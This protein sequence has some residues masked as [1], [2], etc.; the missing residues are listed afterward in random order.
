VYL[1]G[2]LKKRSKGTPWKRRWIVLEDRFL[3]YFKSNVE[4]KPLRTIL[5][6]QSVAVSFRFGSKGRPRFVIHARGGIFHFVCD[7]ETEFQQWYESLDA[8]LHDTSSLPPWESFHEETNLPMIRRG[9]AILRKMRALALWLSASAAE[10]LP[11]LGSAMDTSGPSSSAVTSSPES[12]AADAY[13]L[14]CGVE[15]ETFSIDTKLRCLR[16]P[17]NVAHLL[18]RLFPE[19]F[20]NFFSY[21][22]YCCSSA[23]FGDLIAFLE[24]THGLQVLDTSPEQLKEGEEDAIMSLCEVIVLFKLTGLCWSRLDEHRRLILNYVNTHC[25]DVGPISNLQSD[26]A[27][28]LV[29]C[30]MLTKAKSDCLNM[31]E[32]REKSPAERIQN[33]LQVAFHQFGVI[34]LLEV[35]D[36]VEPPLQDPFSLLVYTTQLKNVI[37]TQI[38]FSLKPLKPLFLKGKRSLE[39]STE[40][41]LSGRR[42]SRATIFVHCA[43][44]WFER[45]LRLDDDRVDSHCA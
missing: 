27:D 37:E 19:S 30:S 17:C 41:Q 26:L 11:V 31:D 10:Q 33:A 18:H 15:G 34:P 42:G 12:A 40:L 4:S 14:A 28:G 39:L 24:N 36:V 29:W 6:D 7:N 35:I 3:S 43:R 25:S 16:Q 5:L 38:S 8:V 22:P 21:K 1:D 2:Y 20:A 44:D 45:K 32:M 23:T 13:N 9:N